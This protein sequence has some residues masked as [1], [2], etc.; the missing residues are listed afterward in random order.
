MNRKFFF[1]EKKGCEE[2][3]SDFMQIEYDEEF[4]FLLKSHLKLYFF[5][6]QKISKDEAL[7]KYHLLVRPRAF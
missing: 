6:N 5:L 2:K 4:F 3:N 7:V 1:D